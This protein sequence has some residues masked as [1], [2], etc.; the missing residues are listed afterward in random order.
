M[1]M[2]HQ[3]AE[4][5]FS[6][7]HS[8]VDFLFLWF[9]QELEGLFMLFGV[10]A[11]VRVAIIRDVFDRDQTKN[12]C[13]VR[14]TLLCLNACRI[15]KY[16]DFWLICFNFHVKCAMDNNT[17][18][19]NVNAPHYELYKIKKMLVCWHFCQQLIWIIWEGS[20]LKLHCWGNKIIFLFNFG[21]SCALFVFH[22]PQFS[23]L[24]VDVQRQTVFINHLMQQKA[25][26]QTQTNWKK[27]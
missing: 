4:R 5:S 23:V 20:V 26:D 7:L 21:H 16:E 11:L 3:W 15:W 1:C 8:F 17:D 18:K 25:S 22:Q 9:Q 13:V 24:G 27:K 10:N 2:E 12:K 6:H 19:G 14:D